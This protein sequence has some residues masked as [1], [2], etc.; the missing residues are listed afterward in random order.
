MVTQGNHEKEKIPFFTDAFASYNARWKM[1]FEESESTSN[2]KL[3]G[4]WDDG[5][6]TTVLCSWCGFRSK[7]VNQGKSDP[8]GSVHIT[9]GDGGNREGLAQN[10]VHP[11]PEWSMFCEASF[12]HGELKIVNSTHAFWS[13]HRNDDDGP[14]RSD[15]VWIT[16]TSLIGS[17]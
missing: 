11:K 15:Q 12:C 3:Q 6:G 13:W 17:E 10:Y 16:V 7:R 2:L 4:G 5:H 14:V 9:I 8:C 1:P